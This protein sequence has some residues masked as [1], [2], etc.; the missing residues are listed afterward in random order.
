MDEIEKKALE[1]LNK[2]MNELI[3]EGKATLEQGSDGS[4]N[5]VVCPEKDCDEVRSKMGRVILKQDS[6]PRDKLP[7]MFAKAGFEFQEGDDERVVKTVASDGSVDRD[8]GHLAP[9]RLGPQRV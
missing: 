3:A 6:V 4:M 7:A 8:G 2:R 9:G 1:E 5:L